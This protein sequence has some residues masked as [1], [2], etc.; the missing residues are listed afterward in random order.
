MSAALDLQ[1]LENWLLNRYTSATCVK[2]HVPVE[3][4]SHQ[5]CLTLK[6]EERYTETALTMRTQR[7]FEISYW[8]N[9]PEE[10]LAVMD[11]AAQSWYED[12]GIRLPSGDYAMRL[13]S[14]T[15]APL[16]TASEL[17]GCLGTLTVEQRIQQHQEPVAKMGAIETA[18]Q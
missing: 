6:K 12:K 11:D 3:P 15:Y 2:H 4:S 18:F 7:Q 16:Q 9:D 14:F 10:A 13:L 8:H 17:Y 5:F 1:V